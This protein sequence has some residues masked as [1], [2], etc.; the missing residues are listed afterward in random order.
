VI[1]QI[2]LTHKDAD[3]RRLLRWLKERAMKEVSRDQV[4]VQ[5]LHR[6]RDAEATQ[7]I[8]ER[9]GRGGWLR[10]ADAQRGSAGRPAMRWEVN[11]RLW[12]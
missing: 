3:A 7:A 12:G 11:P 1:R 2:G 4:R 6:T 5:V 8:M 10:R 9:L